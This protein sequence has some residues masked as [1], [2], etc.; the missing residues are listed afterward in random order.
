M[1]HLVTIGKS[2]D[3]IQ[4]WMF[5]M[6]P[7][8][9]CLHD[10]VRR[11]TIPSKR[12]VVPYQASVIYHLAKQF[13]KGRALEIGSALG[14]SL[15]FICAAMPRAKKVVG[16]NPKDVEYEWAVT[17]VMIH[18]Y[19]QVVA[20]K[21]TSYLNDY[22]GA[23]LDFIFVDG[24][25]DHV[26]DDVPWFNILRPGGLILFHDYS[27]ADS[28]RPTPHVYEV[29]NAMQN[30]LGRDFDVAVIDNQGV[31]MV[32]FYRREDETVWGGA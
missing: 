29:V 22:V 3:E 21:S 7:E 30:D 19:A 6:H 2:P 28:K 20:L 10:A 15:S 17:A 11:I 31:G 23:E 18:D 1:E 4:K 25:H 24:S 16:L 13:D 32:G 5:E 27:P 14:Y 9:P 12:E 26:E 8:L